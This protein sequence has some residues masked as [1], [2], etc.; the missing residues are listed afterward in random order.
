MFATLTLAAAMLA[1]PAPQAP[2]LLD[3]NPDPDGKVRV[4]VVRPQRRKVVVAG[5]AVRPDGKPFQP[6]EEREIEVQVSTRVE[7]SEV[8]D[9]TVT[10]AGGREV[11]RA[12]AL[13]Q[14]AAGGV[15]VASSDG[16]KVDPRYLKL[17]RDDVLVLVSPELVPPRTPPAADPALDAP[18]PMRPA[19]RRKD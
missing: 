5:G 4:Q 2:R 9:L 8:K 12:A 11:E 16:R 3:L 18:L 19:P 17:F 7:L 1:D 15:V 13:K 6:A 10:T 14:L